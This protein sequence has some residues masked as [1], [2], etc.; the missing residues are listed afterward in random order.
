MSPKLFITG[1][2]GYVGGSVLHAIATAHPEY[3]ITVLLRNIPA[4][5]ST[6]YP[7]VRIVTGTYD[8]TSVL[9][10]EAAQADIVV[11]NGDSDHEP[12]LNALITGL[13][14]KEKETGKPGVLL[15]LSG[16][17]IVAD[18]RSEDGLGVRSD[19]TWSD[20]DAHSL[21]KIRSLPDDAL[22]RNTE[23]ILHHT[24]TTHAHRIRIAIMC[25]PSIYGADLGLTRK[26]SVLIPLFVKEIKTLGAAFY[27]KDGTNTRSWV[28]IKDVVRL[29]LHVVET[30]VSSLDDDNASI[31]PDRYFNAN[32]YYFTATQEHDQLSLA[33]AVGAILHA[34]G[35]VPSPD[36]RQITLQELD[37]MATG[38]LDYP[39]MGRYLFASNSRTRADRAGQVWGYKGQEE[40]LFDGLEADVLKVLEES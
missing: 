40:G 33:R 22:H 37:T 18:W 11:H 3:S 16:T 39:P 31:N 12:S 28:H 6:I 19:V 35:V 25:P 30:A 17:G 26:S 38:I 9:T 7:D 8:S 2:T 34:Q 29:Y 32:G 10:S 21:E 4:S 24:A 15:H 13:L 36:P 5:F 14:Q 27:Y 23:N 20:V 1:G